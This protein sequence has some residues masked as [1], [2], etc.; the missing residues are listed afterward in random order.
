MAEFFWMRN[1]MSTHIL[2]ALLPKKKK[3]IISDIVIRLLLIDKKI[4]S[5]VGSN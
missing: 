2:I 3:K 4:I 5:I 1:V